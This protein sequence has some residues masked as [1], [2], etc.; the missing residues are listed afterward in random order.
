MQLAS[1]FDEMPDGFRDIY[2][3]ALD[4]ERASRSA[5]PSSSFLTGR[6][7]GR[8]IEWFCADASSHTARRMRSVQSCVCFS[9]T[10]SPPSHFLALLGLA[11]DTRVG[12]MDYPFDPSRLGVWL[13]P[14]IDT[15][16]RARTGSLELLCSRI[17]R[18]Y[19]ASPGTYLAFFPS[20]EYLSAAA[21]VLAG[22]GL[23]V[24]RQSPSMREA[25]RAAFLRR[26]E[27]ED[28]L[29]MTVAGGIFAE[30][31]DLDAPN[32]R[33][34]I[35]AGPCLPGLDLETRLLERYYSSSGR[36]GFL[37]AAVIP[38]V[39]RV[40]QAAGRLVRGAADRC[41]LVLFDHRFGTEQYLDLLPAHWKIG[42]RLPVLS[43]S[44]REIDR[45]WESG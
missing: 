27:D 4:F 36:D 14:R 15:R 12:R 22:R 28:H 31:V 6:S 17:E 3:A 7:G 24:L 45:F 16:L 10:L 40:I 29:V 41:V 44:M 20:F 43:E 23:P 42:G 13:D 25:D 38:G 26:V 5:S 34:G 30:G 8:W 1:T 2:L 11:P 19:R 35:I 39:N 32:R 37:H 33:G 9:A 18:L 21:S